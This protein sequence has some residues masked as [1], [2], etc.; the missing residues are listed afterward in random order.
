MDMMILTGMLLLGG[1]LNFMKE[2]DLKSARRIA[3]IYVFIV[4]VAALYKWIFYFVGI[5]DADLLKVIGIF[6]QIMNTLA[7]T[8]LGYLT[9]YIVLNFQQATGEA[10]N[11]GL[12]KAIRLTRW[13][14]SISIA[15]ALMIATAGKS[16][17][18]GYML[19]FF[20]Q[21]G[22]ASW[23]LYFIMIAEPIAALGILFHYK[24][25]T[26]LFAAPSLI[27]I[28]LGAI[29]T[30]LHNHDP[31][32]DSYAAMVQLINLSLLLLVYY[33]ENQASK[34][35]PFTPVYIV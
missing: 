32:P 29:Y 11:E 9:A 30:H 10:E 33:F 6:L 34:N 35:H 25:K 24:L 5:K 14:I 23:F 16:Q 31:F 28:M 19:D 1:L 7:Y 4:L 22:Y 18:M 8:L 21:S 2:L 12:K 15:N 3:G 27:I 13:A 17:N 20:R 26:G